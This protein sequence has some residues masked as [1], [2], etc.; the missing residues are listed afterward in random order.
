M[1]RDNFARMLAEVFESPMP[2]TQSLLV[3]VWLT[4]VI[5]L[6][7]IGSVWYCMHA[8]KQ[9]EQRAILH[10]DGADAVGEITFLGRIGKGEN[11]VRYTFNEGRDSFSG[12][13][14]VPASLMRGLRQS[15]R[16]N[17]KYLPSNPSINHPALWEWSLISDWPLIFVFLVFLPFCL[18][19]I[20]I[21]KRYKLIS[22]S[23]TSGG[24]IAG[25]TSI[26][27]RAQRES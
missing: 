15:D 8:V 27:T 19:P 23:S 21:Y 16:I 20:Q 24:S 3:L 6:T 13:A 18:F 5:G 2:L 4:L 7:T 14:Q 11:V 9:V 22:S 1:T 10:R 26:N 12:S 25:T 17:V